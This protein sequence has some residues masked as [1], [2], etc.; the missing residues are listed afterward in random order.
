MMLLKRYKH[1]Q[2]ILG[3]DLIVRGFHAGC[4]CRRDV[5]PCVLCLFP[6]KSKRM[7]GT[8]FRL[9]CSNDGCL[10]L[11][12]RAVGYHFMPLAYQAIA[13][14]YRTILHHTIP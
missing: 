4:F 7:T 6:G 3:D 9:R 11:C 8:V 10:G 13:I 14:L 12:V 1:A 5:H 2:E